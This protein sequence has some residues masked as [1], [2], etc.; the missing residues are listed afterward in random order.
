MN[1]LPSP[2]SIFIQQVSPTPL[3]AIWVAQNQRGLV[4]IGLN[5]DRGDFV[6]A[7]EN[8]ANISV[9]DGDKPG[10]EIERQ[11]RDY[12]TG[13]L[14][15]FELPI[16]WSGM[17]SFQKKVLR[18]TCEIPY[19]ETRP[20]GQIAAMVGKPGAAQ[21]VGRAEATNP[22]PLVIPCHRVIGA[23]GSLRGYGGGLELKAWL[24]ALEAEKR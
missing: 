2:G 1:Q 21:A 13:K 22:L 17:T 19:G 11:L 23:D 16:D 9:Q 7:W 8:E 5:T 18:A 24:L 12:L 15:S 20:Y 4:A 3:G 10:G 14:H 6:A